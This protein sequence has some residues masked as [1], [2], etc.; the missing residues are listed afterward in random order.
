ME[1]KA[2][3]VFERNYD[4]L[5]SGVRFVVNQG[6]SRSSKTYSLCQLIILYALQNPNKVISIV[7]KTFPALRASVMRDFFEVMKEM[8]LYNQQAHNKSEHIYNF[9]NGSM[10]EFFSV[11]DEQKVRGRK[12]DIAWCNEANE[13]WHEDFMQLNMRTTGQMIF[14]YNPS[15][16]DSWIYTL[17]EDDKVVIKSTYRDNPFLEKAIVKQIEGLKDT[18][19]ELYQ[20]YALGERAVSRENVYR[21]WEVLDI[22]PDRFTQFVYGLDFGYIHPTALVKIWYW[23]DEVYIEEVIYESYLTSADLIEKMNQLNVDRNTAIVADYARPEMIAEIRQEGYYVI[24]A[25]KRVEKGINAVKTSKVY[26]ARGTENIQRENRN[27]KYKKVSGE[28]RDDVA[29]RHDDAM[30]AIRYAVLWVKSFSTPDEG[31]TFSF[32]L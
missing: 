17:P 10:V 12:R 27:Y 22:K 29:K 24:N 9:P 32:Y 4:A 26:L 19:E 31:E 11:D 8:D 23:E 1:I 21:P 3:I 7:R 5:H 18:D 25:D 30:D 13:L 20:I 16:S 2:T 28:V 15:D 6:G 14:D